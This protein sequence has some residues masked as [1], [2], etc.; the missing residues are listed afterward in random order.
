MGRKS[1]CLLVKKL[2]VKT[3]RKKF[4]VTARKLFVACG[5]YGVKISHVIGYNTTNIP[6]IF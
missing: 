1:N 6:D 2:N 4:V 3:K 5:F